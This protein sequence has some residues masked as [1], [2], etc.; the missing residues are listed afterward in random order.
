LRLDELLKSY[1]KR[2]PKYVWSQQK[3]QLIIIFLGIVIAFVS[4]L[5]NFNDR[6]VVILIL[7]ALVG[8]FSSWSI[9]KA[10]LSFIHVQSQH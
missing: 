10:T 2:L 7:T 6:A 4:E 9:Y 1:Q 5:D 8:A 3:W